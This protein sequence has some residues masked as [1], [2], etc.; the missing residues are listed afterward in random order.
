V[1]PPSG[2]GRA[3]LVGETGRYVDGEHTEGTRTV[4]T[5]TSQHVQIPSRYG[6]PCTTDRYHRVSAEADYCY[7]RTRIVGCASAVCE[8]LHTVTDLTVED[9]VKEQG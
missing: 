9:G 4:A 6:G 7:S 8:P 2:E 5:L 3:F 1:S